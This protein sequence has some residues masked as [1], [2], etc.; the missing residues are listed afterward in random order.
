MTDP[1]SVV[2]PQMAADR[3]RL[4]AMLH[5]HDSDLPDRVVFAVVAAIDHLTDP[6]RLSEPDSADVPEVDLADPVGVIRAVNARLTAAAGAGPSERALACAQAAR[7]LT[8][9]QRALLGRRP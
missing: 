3:T 5:R 2:S 8:D 1:E 7:E 6:Q 4:R 9:A